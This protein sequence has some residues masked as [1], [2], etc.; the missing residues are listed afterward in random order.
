MRYSVWWSKNEHTLITCAKILVMTLLDDSRP[1]HSQ[2]EFILLGKAKVR[3]IPHVN[4]HHPRQVYAM[5][6]KRHVRQAGLEEPTMWNNKATV[7]IYW[8]DFL[9]N[10]LGRILCKH[11]LEKKE[12]QKL[13]HCKFKPGKTHALTVLTSCVVSLVPCWIS[14]AFPCP[15]VYGNRWKI[16]SDQGLGT[17]WGGRNL[18]AV[19]CHFLLE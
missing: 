19:E 5:T 6:E 10:F 2:L 13:W 18:T 16:V 8:I 17:R 9:S 1:T 11:H 7:A 12:E 15:N 4:P 3:G 14:N